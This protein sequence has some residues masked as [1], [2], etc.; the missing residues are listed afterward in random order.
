[1]TLLEKLVEKQRADELADRPFADKLGIAG[2]QWFNI[3]KDKRG[4][5]VKTLGNVLQMYPE[6]EP[7]VLTYIR[8]TADR[9]AAA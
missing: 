1:M 8:E 2:A 5:G 4:M 3:R 7:D 6:L 9:K